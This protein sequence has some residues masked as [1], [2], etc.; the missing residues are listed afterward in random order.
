MKE[1]QKRKK[2]KK[3]NLRKLNISRNGILIKDSDSHPGAL[4]NKGCG[5][6]CGERDVSVSGNR[7]ELKLC[8]SP[9]HATPV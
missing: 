4:R 9:A 7:L 1:K 5:K 6:E 8:R 2:N 3:K